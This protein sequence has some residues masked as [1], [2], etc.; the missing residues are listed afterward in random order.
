[1]Q[2]RRR[3]RLLAF[4]GVAIVMLLA[5]CGS[6]RSTQVAPTRIQGGTATVALLPGN[7]F[8]WIFPL[9]SF[10][11]TTAANLE[12]SE[13]LMWRPLYWFGAPISGSSSVGVDEA[14]SIALPPKLSYP[15]GSSTVATITLKHWLWSNGSPVTSRDVEFWYDLMRYGGGKDIWWDYLPGQIPDNV[16]SFKII[17]Q[18]KFAI[19]FDHKYKEPWIYNELGQLIPIPQQSWD[20]ESANGPVGNY[21]LSSSG[22]HKVLGFLLK[23]NKEL[24]T[25]ASNPLWKVVDGPWTLSQFT[26]STGDATY[27]RNKDYSG[28]FTGSIHAVRVISFTSDTAEFDTLLSSSGISYG[29]VPFNN[30][31]EIGRVEADGYKV[32][33][34]NSWGITYITLNFASPQAGPLFKQLYIRQAM[35]HLINQAGYISTFLENYGFPTY[36]PVPLEPASKFVSP[37]QE[38]NPY[39]Y[40]PAAATALLREHGWTIRPNGTDT[41]ARPGTAAD[42]CGAGITAG[43][44]LAF[45][46]QYST[47]VEAADEEVAAFQSSLAQA[48]IT[49]T[50]SGA[51][52]DTV[53]GDDVP[54]TK[55]GCWEMNYYGAGWDFDPGYAEPDGSVLFKSNGIDNVGFYDSTRANAL[56]D[57]IPS[58]GLQ[59]LYAYENYIAKQ[60][61]MLWMPQ[62]D[63]QISAVSDKLKGAY[64]QD[65]LTNVYPELWYFVK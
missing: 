26:A 62:F 44:K 64:P 56:M 36:G 40:N 58:G 28:P 2:V 31:A 41:C 4:T 50:P 48:G 32:Q 29:Y 17:S 3:V 19:T 24:D 25:Y 47:G 43:E 54:C 61:P 37:Q 30:A 7:D 35:Q 6:T 21:D 34:W 18:T 38:K 60:L 11:A 27:V 46:M 39:P 59:A 12:Y 15:K 9:L 65:P 63:E 16:T 22:A 13:Y 1:M 33:A 10:D 8:S 45:T 23:Q 57:D 55:S 53:I 49:L 42:E 20:K 5:A 52:F 14:Y 51:S